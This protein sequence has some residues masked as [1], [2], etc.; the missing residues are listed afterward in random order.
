MAT[1]SK[2]L[3]DKIN[4]KY[5]E[6]S[7]A[8]ANDPYFKSVP[9]IPSGVFSLDME[10]GGGWPRSRI[11]H[12]FGPKSAGKSLLSYKSIAH[13]QRLCRWCSLMLAKCT[14]G[15]KEPM[16]GAWVDV[17]SCHDGPWSESL[18]VDPELLMVSKPE[19]SEQAVDVV[20]F[21]IRSGEVDI[22]VM[23][24]VAAL[25]PQELIEKSAEENMSPGSIARI[26]S[27]ACKKWTAALNAKLAHPKTKAIAPNLCTILLINQLRESISRVPMPAAPTGGRAIRFYSSIELALNY[28]K[29]DIEMRETMDA[30]KHGVSQTIHFLTEKNKTYS[31]KREGQFTF[32]FKTRKFD[33]EFQIFQ[34]AQRF[35]I[36]TSEKAMFYYGDRSFRGEDNTFKALVA[37]GT[38][39]KIELQVR[40]RLKDMMD[41]KAGKP[42]V[43]VKTTEPVNKFKAAAEKRKAKKKETKKLK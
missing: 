32:D 11:H 12:I 41:W 40:Q 7:I 16:T 19:T 4:E 2:A 31:Q 36:V 3:M 22:I 28:A 24:S 27:T 20:E 43:E 38:M 1:K 18:G 25:V 21:L 23:D 8:L 26:M 37:D 15:A 13:A 33:N 14:C 29:S 9:R 5:G 34:Y 35:E 39:K 30:Q 10:T 17:E 42:A 6:G